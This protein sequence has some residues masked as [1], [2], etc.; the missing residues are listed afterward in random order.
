MAVVDLWVGKAGK[1]TGRHGRGLRYRAVVAGHPS[2]A[3]RTKQEARAHESALLSKGKPGPAG[4]ATVDELV[5]VWLAGKAGLSTRGLV[6]CKGDANH[7]RARWRGVPA[8]EVATHDV[9]AW[10]AGMTVVVGTKAEPVTKR[11][12]EA[13]RR[14]VF[15]CLRGA[16]AVAVAEG[17]LASNPCDGVRVP[18]DH[19]REGVFLTLAQVRAVAAA[20]GR[21]AALVWLLAT[22]GLR[23]GE[24]VNLRV[25]DVDV[26]RKRLRVTRAKGKRGR[27]VGVPASVL[28]M[29]ELEG[30]GAGEWLFL[31][32]IG[33]QVDVDH[34]RARWWSR[35]CKAA[36]VSARIHDLRH[37]AASLAIAQGADIK[38]V[39]TM[40]GH[41]TATLTLDT[42]GH[43][44]ESGLDDLAA[45]MDGAIRS[46][47]AVPKRDPSPRD[48]D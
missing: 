14:R 21:Y 15:Q 19:R 7:V 1:A 27:D 42:Y 46:A 18:K 4:R 31:N 41:R 30:R 38:A 2:R 35:G 20:T 17:G 39:Q 23:I 9:Q 13:L 48:K 44:W 33:G 45:R 29:L 26:T 25:G 22:T 24:A 28:A 16:L 47:T 34:F 40:L 8:S 6:A 10:I 11:A 3:F 36:G 5:A 37:T 32:A 43:L 12:S